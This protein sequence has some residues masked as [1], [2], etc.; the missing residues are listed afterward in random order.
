MGLNMNIDNI[1]QA[2][3]KASTV[4]SQINDNVRLSTNPSTSSSSTGATPST[5]TPTNT[6]CSIV[7]PDLYDNTY[8]APIILMER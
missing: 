6:K 5:P 4:I 7:N 8:V 1:G 2:L 3:D